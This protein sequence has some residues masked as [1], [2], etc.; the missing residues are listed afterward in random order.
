MKTYFAK[1]N[2]SMYDITI[3]ELGNVEALYDVLTANNVSSEYVPATGEA[4]II[5]NSGALNEA[6]T[7]KVKEKQLI[8]ANITP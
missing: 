6:V 8:F 2:Q 4:V 3:Q 7:R 5:P 1:A